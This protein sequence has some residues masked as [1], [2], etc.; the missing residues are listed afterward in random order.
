VGNKVGDI[1]VDIG[2]DTSGFQKGAKE[3]IGGAGDIAGALSGIGGIAL[4]ATAALGAIF[5]AGI[6]EASDMQTS[7][8]QLNAVLDSTK[9]VAGVT[10]DSALQI[11]AS[12]QK[13]TRFSD[14]AVLSGENMLLTFTKIGKD[15]FPDATQTMLDMSQALG[16]DVKSSAMQLGKALND[17]IEGVS[18]LRR[19]GVTFSNDQERVIKQ[20][21]RTGKTAEAQKLILKELNTEFGGSAKAAGQTFA[22]QLDILKNKFGEIAEG[23]GNVFLPAITG[24][25]SG[26]SS[27]LDQLPVIFDGIRG[28][29]GTALGPIQ[30]DLNTLKVA[31]GV[32][33][34]D[35]FGADVQNIPLGDRISKAINDTFPTIQLAIGDIQ[36]KIGGVLKGFGI[37]TGAIDSVVKIVE[38][39]FEKISNGIQGFIKELGG[40]DFSG[41]QKLLEISAAA[42]AGIATTIGA[43]GIG[44]LEGLGDA[45][46]KFGAGLKDVINGLASA[47]NGDVGGA[48]GGIGA[49]LGKIAEGALKIPMDIATRVGGLLNIDV[50][51]GLAAWQGVGDQLG[52][53]LGA[54]FGPD[55]PVQKAIQPFK[56][57][58]ATLSGDVSN[59]GTTITNVITG[60]AQWLG[61]DGMNL[62]TAA[63]SAVTGAV[64]KILGGIAGA[65]TGAVRS[66]IL[67]ITAGLMAARDGGVPGLDGV[68]NGMQAMDSGL[69]KALGGDVL[70]N[71]KYQVGEG[72][73]PELLSAGGKLF[74]IPGDQGK[75]IPN[76]QINPVVASSGGGKAKGVDI[77]IQS[78]NL[79]GVQNPA[80][81][82]DSLEKEAGRRGQKLA[83]RMGT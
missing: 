82:L 38:G 80:Q 51:G 16:Q 15:V 37:D 73:K 67:S 45:L 10:A 69:P 8:T 55:G 35:I 28:A 18:A 26:I 43:A 5:V 27:G 48:L 50:Q 2:A 34:N 63:F 4:G 59:I 21:V 9:G 64:G 77:N 76:N 17:P 6:K 47:G 75:V 83:Y 65:I 56:D 36:K 66:A 40:A 61:K 24:I 41:V 78:L 12:L 71:V 14:D 20:L 33:W 31:F 19:V 3:V 32:A 22:G 58:W 79:Y 7:V 46:P 72:N 53:I 57:M 29:I 23:I 42:F 25:V 13:V 49:G 62:M 54:A 68:I 44:L 81:M 74:M 39:P 60:A 11:A 52:A 70:A 30:N 1:H